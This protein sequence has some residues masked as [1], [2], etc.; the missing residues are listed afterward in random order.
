MNS[1]QGRAASRAGV[2][3]FAR[4]WWRW[5]RD[6]RGWIIGLVVPAWFA[7]VGTAIG[8][9]ALPLAL[10]WPKGA[11]GKALA[12]IGGVVSLVVLT[13][14]TAGIGG[15]LF[16]LFALAGNGLL[17]LVIYGIYRWLFGPSIDPHYGA[18]WAEQ[19][20]TAD[21]VVEEGRHPGEDVL[22][23]QHYGSSSAS[24]RASRADGR[25]ATS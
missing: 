10:V 4:W 7:L 5:W 13:G 23:A 2:L 19:R 17:A 24:G 15:A 11:W 3:G 14:A 22:L 8:A 18:R 9:P 12:L 21:M 25:W 6:T 20:D 16:M 1:A